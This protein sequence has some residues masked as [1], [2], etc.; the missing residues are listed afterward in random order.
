MIAFDLC[1]DEDH[2]FEA[3]FQ[4]RESF[5]AQKEQDLLT[6]PVCGSRI[7][8]KVPSAVAVH[9]GSPSKD[10]NTPE[11]VLNELINKVYTMVEQNT[12]DVGP[13]FAQEALKMHYGVTSVRNIRG[14]ATSQEEKTLKEEDIPFMKIPVPA[15]NCTEDN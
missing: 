1:C 8:R 11:E 4:D 5:E 14:V 10:G 6:C 3:W 9:T 7:I 13:A 15:K 12:E 2:I